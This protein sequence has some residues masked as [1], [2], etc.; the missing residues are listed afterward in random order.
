MQAAPRAM[1]EQ[2]LMTAIDAALRQAIA[3][4]APLDQRLG[5]IRDAVGALSAEFATAVDRLVARLE[6]GG[7]GAAA[8]APGQPMPPFVLPDEAGR[9]VAMP[10]LLAAGP[11]VVNFHRGHWCPYCR[12]H[13]AALAE[14]A[15]AISAAG[16]SLVIITPERGRYGARM[17]AEAEDR[18][19]VLTDMDN[20][21]AMSLNLAIW[22]GAELQ[23]MLGAAGWDL[24][25]Y[26]GNPAWMLPVPAT[27]VVGT[28]GLVVARH[29]DPDYRR[30]MAV[31]D[32]LAALG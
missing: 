13:R 7:A 10:R 25:A 5:L 18:F 17:R 8:P 6:A 14:A 1:T 16:A 23:A 9:L 20:G 24:A 11:L 26:Q 32:L 27:F 28:D 21:Y 12:L 15:P 30:R 19:P 31:E 4:D 29:V 2:P 22:L 3:L